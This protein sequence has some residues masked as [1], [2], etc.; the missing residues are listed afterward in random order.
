M[1]SH[2]GFQVT[3]DLSLHGKEGLERGGTTTYMRVDCVERGKSDRENL[4][5]SYFLVLMLSRLLSSTHSCCRQNNFAV[6]LLHMVKSAH[7]LQPLL[8]S[9]T[10]VCVCAKGEHEQPDEWLAILSATS[11]NSEA[12]GVRGWMY[13]P[14]SSSAS[15]IL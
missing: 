6:T 2:M 9:K 12:A 14:S 8:S 4:K 10:W 3:A 1:Y 13:L 7:G 5:Q 11:S 15:Y